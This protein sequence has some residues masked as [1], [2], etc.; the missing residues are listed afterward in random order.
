MSKYIRNA[1]SPA[2]AGLVSLIVATGAGAQDT[3]APPKDGRGGHP[4]QQTTTL[5]EIQV[6]SNKKRAPPR[7]ADAGTRSAGRATPARYAGCPDR[8]GRHLRQQHVGRDQDQPHAAAEYSQSITVV[9]KDFVRDQGAQS[10]TDVTRYIPGVAIHQGEAIA[11]SSSFAAWIPAPTFSSTGFA[12]TSST[13]RDLYNT[14][15]IELL[16][17]PSAL[18]FGRGVGGGLLNRTLKEA[19]SPGFMK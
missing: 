15:S 8:N 1:K 12:T 2:F 14:Q 18:T 11:M 10:V 16:R 3:P 17:G 5:P 6:R 19:D 13:T 4:R 9:T 7:R